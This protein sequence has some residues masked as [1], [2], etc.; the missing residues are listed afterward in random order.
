MYT[1]TSQLEK[2]LADVEKDIFYLR[3]IDRWEPS[4]YSL[5]RALNQRKEELEE[6]IKERGNV[7]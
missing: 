1:T 7:E 4:D 6:Q 3:M 5:S 2:E